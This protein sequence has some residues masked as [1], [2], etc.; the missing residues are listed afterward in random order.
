MEDLNAWSFLKDGL[1]TMV[2]EPENAFSNGQLQQLAVARAFISM[3]TILLLDEATSAMDQ[4][5]IDQV[6]KHIKEYRD[7]GNTL[8]VIIVPFRIGEFKQCD[9]IVCLKSDG[10]FGSAGTHDT[11]FADSECDY[12]KYCQAQ[13]ASEETQLRVEA[14]KTDITQQ[15]QKQLLSFGKKKK[16]PGKKSANDVADQEELEYIQDAKARDDAD[17]RMIAEQKAQAAKTSY[18]RKI[19]REN[20]SCGLIVLGLFTCVLSGAI[21]P[22]FGYL[23]GD[24]VYILSQ[25][26]N[27]WGVEYKLEEVPVFLAENTAY[28]CAVAVGLGLTIYWRIYSFGVLA[29]RLTFKMRQ[30]VY[31]SML[32]KH[33]GFFDE[34]KHTTEYLTEILQ[35]DVEILNGVSVEA[36]GPYIEA[37]CGVATAVALSL[38]EERDFFV[39]CLPGYPVLMASSYMMW[40]YQK[41][42]IVHAEDQ[43]EDADDYTTEMILNYQTAQSFGFPGMLVTKYERMLLKHSRKNR[44]TN[45]CVGFMFGLAEGCFIATFAYLFWAGVKFTQDNFNEENIGFDVEADQ[46]NVS[47]FCTVFGSLCAGTAHFFGPN[48]AASR[49]AAERV[50]DVLEYRTKIDA[51]A[52]NENPMLKDAHDLKGKIEFRNVW[53]R[54][55]YEPDKFVLRGC[56][57]VIEPNMDVCVIGAVGSGKG[58]I[59]DLLMRF[60]DPDFGE[61]LLDGVSITAYKLHPLRKQISVV[62]REHCLFNYSILENILYGERNASNQDVIDAVAIANAE[63]FVQEGKF[64]RYDYTAESLLK[65]MEANKDAIVAK[66]GLEKFDEEIEVLEE[67]ADQEALEGI[68]QSETG[69]WDRR[70]EDLKEPEL[71][72]G[73][74]KTIGTRG[75]KLS[76]D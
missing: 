53:F 16:A 44:C 26:Y 48:Y 7:E 72:R 66:I 11:L 1:D 47:I 21:Q 74:S 9:Q 39:W 22:L 71:P 50:Y 54:Y 59:L 40:K 76:I 2:G 37:F 70:A 62:M 43:L 61:I 49:Q 68:F 20:D 13:Q 30:K 25:N 73:Y 46:I 36:V 55:P 14:Q 8:T 69:L 45:F 15:L 12:S 35:D 63:D 51:I 6:F 32:S 28:V 58:A 34:D 65:T 23:F 57:F 17:D 60:Y 42:L 27:Q 41:G 19:W 3:P 29:L 38:T 31:G 67:M 5:C 75:C 64:H 24:Q 56:S 4:K 18:F 33:I 52:M 10:S